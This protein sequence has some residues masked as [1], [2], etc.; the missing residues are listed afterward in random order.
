MTSAS[1]PWA[2]T[3]RSTSRPLPSGIRRSVTIRSNWS[4]VSALTAS[5]TP[6]A[7]PTWW[8]RLRRSNASVERAELS[9]ST[10]RML[11]M[12]SGRR[13]GQGDGESRA[14][15]GLGLDVDV[16]PVGGHDA[17][18]DGQAQARPAGLLRKERLE[19][20]PPF[21]WRNAATRVGHRDDDVAVL[22]LHV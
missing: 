22:S 18:D 21:F 16:T 7:S 8:P 3:A 2:F 14:L 1:W 12:R 19:D 9:S 10:T 17:P 15:P 4:S 20:A 5:V 11:A 13:H 6:G